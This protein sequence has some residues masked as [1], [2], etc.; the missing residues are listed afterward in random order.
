M[1]QVLSTVW[2]REATVGSHLPLSAWFRD[3]PYSFDERVSVLSE[4][5]RAQR[6]TRGGLKCRGAR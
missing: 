2:L 6:V 3:T 5:L 1:C 4:S